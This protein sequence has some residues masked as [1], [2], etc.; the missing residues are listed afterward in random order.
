[1]LTQLRLWGFCFNP[2]SFYFIFD[3]NADIPKFI[4]AEVN[5]TPWNQRHAYLLACDEKGK[6]DAE[7]NKQF[8]VSPFNPIDMQYHW[9]STAPDE[10]LVIH[11]ENHQA[12]QDILNRHMD[13]TLT[14]KRE[15]WSC[16]RLNKIVWTMPWLAVKI[17]VAIY[18]QALKLFFK[19]VP[20]YSHNSSVQSSIDP[21]K[22]LRGAGK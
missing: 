8:H 14:L 18:W 2:V 20:F 15:N 19:G 6:V 4:L 5:N 7:F 9:I 12:S 17:P 1:L 21:T 13:A 22:S 16:K 3:Q 10:Q 11:M